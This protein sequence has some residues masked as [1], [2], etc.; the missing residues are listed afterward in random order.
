MLTNISHH[1]T[2]NLHVCIKFALIYCTTIFSGTNNPFFTF[3][4]YRLDNIVFIKPRE[5]MKSI[6]N[7]INIIFN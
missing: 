5:E 1:F 4:I 2:K 7:L 6:S 3:G